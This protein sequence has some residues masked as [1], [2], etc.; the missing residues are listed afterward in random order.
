MSRAFIKSMFLLCTDFSS[1][2][3]ALRAEIF[4]VRTPACAR[5]FNL[6]YRPTLSIIQPPLQWAK[7]T[8]FRVHIGRSVALTTRPH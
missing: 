8:F 6:F 7:G 4:G 5:F 2:G 3:T 1:A